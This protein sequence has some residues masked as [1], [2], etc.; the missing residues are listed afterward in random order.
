AHGTA[1][2]NIQDSI[3]PL[4]PPLDQ[5]FFGSSVEIGMHFF[6][7]EEEVLFD[8]V[9]KDSFVDKEVIDSFFLAGPW[10]TGGSRNRA[11][12]VWKI[13][14]Q[15]VQ[16]SRLTGTRRRRHDE[17]TPALIRRFGFVRG[18]FQVRS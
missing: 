5:V 18:F 14:Q 13:L 17:N 15:A 4:V 12:Y 9:S 6:P 3:Q 1:S 8:H 10:R 2:V 7:F 11:G 16:K